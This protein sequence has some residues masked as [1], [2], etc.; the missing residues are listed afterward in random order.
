MANETKIDTLSVEIDYSAGVANTGLTQLTNTLVKLSGVTAPAI[1]NLKS[2]STQLNRFV[3]ISTQLNQTNLSQFSNNI[4]NLSSAVKPLS[5]LG[6]S[7]L[8]SFI[9]QLKKIPDLN[10]ALDATTIS[11]FSAKIKELSN[12]MSPLATNMAKVGTVLS[13][14]PS[15][16]NK[17]SSYTNKTTQNMSSL[18]SVSKLINFSAIIAGASRVGRALGGF[19]AS[20]NEYVE[21]LNLFTVAMGKSTETAKEWVDTVSDALGLDPAPMMRYMGVFQMIASGFG[22]SADNA[23]KMS[24]NLTQLTYDISSFYNL[25]IDEAAQKVQSAISG[26]LEPV[27]RLGY[28]LDQ[29]TLKQIAL[30]NGIKESITNMTQAEKAQLRYIALLTQNQA[31][32]GDMARTIDDNCGYVMKVA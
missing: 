31:V 20:S 11:Q 28:A 13:A 8:S 10:K 30:N 32:Q 7:N 21:D 27:R 17:V 2:I 12:A 14:L 18:A 6:K 24:K 3:N 5:E 26:E 4:S 15:K 25:N 1:N 9:N 19:I 16:L 23:Y 29:A 22:L